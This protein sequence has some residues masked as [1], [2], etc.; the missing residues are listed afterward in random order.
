MPTPRPDAAPDPGAEQT[1]VLGP[2][3]GAGEAT[4]R[5]SPDADATV[6]LSGEEAESATFL[7]PRAWGGTPQPD[8]D[9]DATVRLP[10]E[11]AE[12]ATFLDPRAWGGTPQPDGTT[13]L[14]GPHQE[15]DTTTLVDPDQPGETTTLIDPDEPAAE[16]G[17]ATTP[18][19]ERPLA[20]GELRRF[21]P[22]VPPRAAAVWHGQAS[23]EA[24]P[25]R[26]RRVGRWLA[27]LAVL[28]LVLAA[29][30]FWRQLRTPA[31]AVTAV[32][33]T[34]DPAG[35][36]CAGTALVTASV[37]T[38]GG[39]GTLHYRWLRS[40]GTTS[41]ELTQEVHPGVHHTDLV[42]R[43]TFDGQGSLQAT[44]TLQLLTPTTRTAGASFP[45]HCP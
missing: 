19:Q 37:E 43:W 5:L 36:G 3:P 29:F 30:L 22:G 34:T 24:A 12:S 14:A 42:L 38:N 39:S 10:G 7:D 6:R 41:E 15:G 4:L 13:T 44:A 23:T 18:P 9:A 32:T 45:Y 16:P 31:L 26:R 1:V 25:P 33:V 21:G 40:D 2:G 27:P 28:L 11:E 17:P 35:P 20:P 8:A